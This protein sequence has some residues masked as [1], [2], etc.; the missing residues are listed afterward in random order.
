MR[1]ANRIA[2]VLVIAT[3][4]VTVGLAE[5]LATPR[6]LELGHISMTLPMSSAYAPLSAGNL[7]VIAAGSGWVTSDLEATI[8]GTEPYWCES[9]LIGIIGILI[10]N[11]SK[12]VSEKLTIKGSAGNVAYTDTDQFTPE[13]GSLN[14][15]GFVVGALP[16]D[17]YKANHKFTMGDTVVGQTFWFYVTNNTI[18]P[19][20]CPAQ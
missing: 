18:N 11:K 17:I 9:E 20:A 8:Y 15:V 3:C 13:A 19:D 7:N 16:A 2:L 12:P 14:V 1:R 4:S 6:S 5:R 10:A